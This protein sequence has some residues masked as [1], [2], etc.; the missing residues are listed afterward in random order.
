MQFLNCSKCLTDIDDSEFSVISSPSYDPLLITKRPVVKLTDENIHRNISI[1]RDCNNHERRITKLPLIIREALRTTWRRKRRLDKQFKFKTKKKKTDY[2]LTTN[3]TGILKKNTKINI[4]S[5]NQDYQTNNNDN[6]YEH[7][8]ELKFIL[9][10]PISFAN[11]NQI[12]N[13]SNKLNSLDFQRINTIAI[14]HKSNWN[15]LNFHPKY[16]QNFIDQDKI[17]TDYIIENYKKIDNA[18]LSFFKYQPIAYAFQEYDN[19]KSRESSGYFRQQKT[20]RFKFNDDYSQKK[21]QQD[22]FSKRHQQKTWDQFDHTAMAN[23]DDNLLNNKNSTIKIGHE[24]FK[25]LKSVPITIGKNYGAVID[26]YS[27]E[28]R[29][30][31]VDPR[32]NGMIFNVKKLLIS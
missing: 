23:I 4:E 32:K 19:K 5:I 29:V 10:P 12:E 9:D 1:P 15:L 8:E 27:S 7:Q 26:D 2:C 11:S 22:I 25:R 3:L 16:H 13:V 20:V 17:Q 14:P 28:I 21:K 30:K 6:N 24:T 31:Q 18:I